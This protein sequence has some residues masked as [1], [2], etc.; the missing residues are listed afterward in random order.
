MSVGN[1]PWLG[2]PH[3]RTQR[4]QI[5]PLDKSTIVSIYPKPIYEVKHTIQPG[6][7]RI[8]AGSYE[9][10]ALLVVGP[11]SWWR[12]LDEEQP[13]LEIPVS[14]VQIAESVVKDYANGLLDCNMADVMPG[15]LLVSNHLLI[16][17]FIIKHNYIR[18]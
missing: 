18:H 9:K 4:A 2:N 10:P 16:L 8:E 1:A 7:F 12:E 3:R 11:S 6:T 17:K 5:N 13:L 15:L 14:S